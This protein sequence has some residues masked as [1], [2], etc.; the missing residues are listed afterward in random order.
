MKYIPGDIVFMNHQYA[1]VKLAQFTEN[2]YFYDTERSVTPVPLTRAI[3]EKNGYVKTEASFETQTYYVKKF[4]NRT[5]TVIFIK[6]NIRVLYDGNFLRFVDYVSDLQHLL[7][8]LNLESNI[9]I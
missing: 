9:I 8:G 4:G 5:I 3:L 7:F 6:D 2:S 1:G